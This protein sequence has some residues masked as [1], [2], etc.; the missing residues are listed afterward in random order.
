[1]LAPVTVIKDK[2]YPKMSPLKVEESLIPYRQADK[3]ED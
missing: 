3:E 2:I 1:M